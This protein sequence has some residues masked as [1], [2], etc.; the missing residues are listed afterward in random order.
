MSPPGIT[1]SN[2]HAHSKARI[3]CCHAANLPILEVLTGP[4]VLLMVPLKLR[5]VKS[6]LLCQIFIVITVAAIPIIIPFVLH[7]NV[8]LVLREHDFTQLQFPLFK[9]HNRRLIVRILEDCIRGKIPTNQ[10]ARLA[11]NEQHAHAPLS[12]ESHQ[13]PD[14]LLV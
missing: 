5:L 11:R 10:V 9:I 14:Q 2:R 1:P 6:L 7:I 13:T 3:M 8:V 12:A 4:I